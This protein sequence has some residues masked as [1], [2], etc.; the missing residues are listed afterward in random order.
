MK[1]LSRDPK[2]GLGNLKKERHSCLR[3]P[4]FQDHK[5]WP[6]FL[7]VLLEKQSSEKPE[8]GE[9]KKK[10]EAI[11]TG[12]FKDNKRMQMI[13]SSPFLLVNTGTHTSLTC[14]PNIFSLSRKLG[15]CMR[16]GTEQRPTCIRTHDQY[17][18]QESSG[19]SP[20]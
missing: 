19:Q 1:I 3:E 10:N 13:F 18:Q 4:W 12:C 17:L 8:L 15:Y 6:V 14:S 20:L 7:R 5:S 16:R 2:R 9:R 11:K